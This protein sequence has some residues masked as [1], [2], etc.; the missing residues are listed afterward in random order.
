MPSSSS[1]TSSAPTY[2]FDPVITTL[3]HTEGTESIFVFSITSSGGSSS[4]GTQPVPPSVTKI[5][6]SPMLQV[7]AT[8]VIDSERGR[9]IVTIG[10]SS[11][12]PWTLSFKQVLDN[13]VITEHNTWD[14]PAHG[15]VFNYV[16]HLTPPVLT[17]DV[18][19]NST[20]P[21]TGTVTMHQQYTVTAIPDFSAG[22]DQLVSLAQRSPV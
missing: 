9:G 5:D 2:K 15:A 19:A 12:Y 21:E 18:Y 13:S 22:R 10:T 6:L 16:K 8:V 20:D 7:A 3:D 1:S 11:L 4:G 17:I 14:I